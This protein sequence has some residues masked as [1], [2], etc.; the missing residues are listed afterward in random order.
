MYLESLVE[1]LEIFNEVTTI[2][3]LY[4]LLVFTKFVSEI[5]TQYLVGFSFAF[6]LSLNMATHV[7][8]LLRSSFR[9]CKHKQKLRNAKK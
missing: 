3:L 6:F 2:I 7:F 1:N 9:D 8:F 5:N 4:H